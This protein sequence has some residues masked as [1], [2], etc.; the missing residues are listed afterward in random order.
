MRNPG[1]LSPKGDIDIKS[2]PSELSEHCGGVGR[3]GE[4]ANGDRGHQ[5]NKAL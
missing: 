3:K 1:T 4:G 2:L 5:E